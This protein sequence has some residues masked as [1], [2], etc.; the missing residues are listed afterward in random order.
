MS[1]F[2]RRGKQSSDTMNNV[3]KAVQLV[4]QAKF[5]PTNVGPIFNY[6]TSC[7]DHRIILM[8]PYF[9]EIVGSQKFWNTSLETVS[10]A[11]I[12]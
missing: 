12:F 3:S 4:T 6:V 10:T 8:L 9:L 1:L 5:R 11:C 2:Y 7:K